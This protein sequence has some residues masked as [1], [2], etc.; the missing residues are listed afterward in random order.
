MR[1]DLL[2]DFGE[3]EAAWKAELLRFHRSQHTRNLHTRNIGF[4]Q[5]VLNLNRQSAA[6]AK[7][8]A[9]YAEA[10]EIEHFS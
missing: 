4:D 7:G 5:R 10:F 9:T 3:H 1:S 8:G 6:K 2:M